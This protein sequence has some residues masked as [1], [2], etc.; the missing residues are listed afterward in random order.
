MTDPLPY[1]SLPDEWAS[2]ARCPVCNASPLAVV[3]R[4]EAADQMACPRCHALF[5]IEQKG[6]RIHFTVLPGILNG[7]IG[8]RWITY[9]EVRQTVGTSTEPQ[10]LSRKSLNYIGIEMSFR[11]GGGRLD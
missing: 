10:V 5:E 11:I 7:P 3:H 6:P 4:A 8:G 9:A 1:N 2:K